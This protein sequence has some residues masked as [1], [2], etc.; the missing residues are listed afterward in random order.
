MPAT[1]L[2]ET[3]VNS[4]A[5]SLARDWPKVNGFP[6]CMRRIMYAKNT[7]NRAMMSTYPRRGRI[8]DAPPGAWNRYTTPW[9]S[10]TCAN[11]A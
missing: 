7:A 8:H 6:P 10:I 1:S 11:S 5:T 4:L 2:N 9:S 3:F